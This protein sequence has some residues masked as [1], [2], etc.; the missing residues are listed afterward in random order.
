MSCS[1]CYLDLCEVLVCD[2]KGTISI[3]YVASLAGE[4]TF[5]L[6]YLNTAKVYTKAFAMNESLVIEFDCLNENY[7]YEGYILD[8][9]NTIVTIFT[10]SAYTAF[11]FCTKQV[12]LCQNN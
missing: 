12:S 9:N 8:P 6:E 3:P 7:C 11:K 5:V 10:D 4:Y 2:E 1:N